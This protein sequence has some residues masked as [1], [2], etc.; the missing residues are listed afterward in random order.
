M[1]S[2]RCRFPSINMAAFSGAVGN[3]FTHAGFIFVEIL[4]E[5]ERADKACPNPIPAIIP[6]SDVRLMNTLS[7]FSAGYITV[8]GELKHKKLSIGTI[9][10]IEVSEIEGLQKTH[11]LALGK[12]KK[13]TR[14]ISTHTRRGHWARR[15]VGSGDERRLE[16]RWIE[17][18]IVNDKD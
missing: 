9:V 18:T 15:W 11:P 6:M 8:F 7:A 17:Q 12:G 3:S 5:W 2:P 10:V 16:K 1:S 13:S 4:G 14:T